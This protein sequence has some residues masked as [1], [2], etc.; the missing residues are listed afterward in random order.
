MTGTTT[1]ADY[2]WLKER[3]QLLLDAYCLTLV[4]DL[5]PEELLRALG[6]EGRRRIVGVNALSGPSSE[7]SGLGRFVGAAPVDGWALMV[8]FNGYLGVTDELMRPLSRGRRVVSHFLNVNAVDRFRWYEDGDLRLGFQPLFA[9]ERY[10][11][12]PDELLAEMRESGFDLT[13]R[14]EDGDYDDYYESLTG[15]SFALA[16]RL[17][18]IRVTPE[19][20][21]TAGF[22][23]GV[24]PRD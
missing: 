16:H 22:L 23:C 1:A 18:G 20:F 24:V 7:A 13:E 5:T 14:D 11:S 3:H 19:L 15:A 12:R 17:T 10:G 9:D 6:A 8:E 21:A 4:R 2:G